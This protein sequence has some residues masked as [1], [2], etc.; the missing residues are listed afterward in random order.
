MLKIHR[1]SSRHIAAE[2]RSGTSGRLNE[3]LTVNDG[4]ELP[5]GRERVIKYFCQK[6]DEQLSVLR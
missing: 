6:V 3:R 1:T 4:R 5:A 2:T